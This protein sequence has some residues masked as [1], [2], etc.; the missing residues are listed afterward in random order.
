MSVRLADCH[1]TRKMQARGFCKNCYDKWLKQQN[2]AYR[3]SQ[4]KNTAVWAKLNPEKWDKIQARRVAKERANP[5]IRRARFLKQKYNLTLSDYAKLLKSQGG[6][7]ALCGR[8]PGKT[9]L[10]VDHC[11]ETQR[12]RGLLCHQCNWYLG[13]IDADRGILE[14]IKEYIG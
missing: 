5:D 10:H 13:T 12:I 4:L 3:N 1:P 7:C 6:C 8:K 11:H 2:P 9:P 14:R